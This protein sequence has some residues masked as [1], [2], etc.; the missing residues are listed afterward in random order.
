MRGGLKRIGAM[1]LMLVCGMLICFTAY[2]QKD[3]PDATSKFVNDFA[4]VISDE[5]E[6]EMSERAKALYEAY[7]EKIQVMVV[8]IESLGGESISDY[9]LR[10]YNA[11]GI[12]LKDVNQGVMILVSIND[13]KTWITTGSGTDDYYITDD[14][15]SEI[16]TIGSPYFKSGEFGTGLKMI[17]IAAIDEFNSRMN[18]EDSAFKTLSSINKPSDIG[19]SENIEEVE[20]MVDIRNTIIIILTALM[21]IS[22]S[23]HLFQLDRNS[24]DKDNIVSLTRKKE[25]YQDELESIKSKYTRL[26]NELEGTKNELSILNFDLEELHTKYMDLSERFE[27]AKRID[28]QIEAKVAKKI[29]ESWDRRANCILNS[30]TPYDDKLEQ[31]QSLIREF[32]SLAEDVKSFITLSFDLRRHI[33]NSIDNRDREAANEIEERI[34]K[35]VNR[36]YKVSSGDYSN[37]SGAKSLYE[38]LNDNARTFVD[39]ALIASVFS[40]L[41]ISERLREEEKNERER[42]RRLREEEA[43]FFSSSDSSNDTSSFDA[44]D[45]GSFDAGDGGSSDGGGGGADW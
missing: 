19:Y 25:R 4:N 41:Q 12:G 18:V 17:Q 32:D 23:L 37:L 36:I 30:S 6:L 8:T 7:P 35:K 22:I 33:K 43:S 15:A 24:K 38:S 26:K 2:A 10:M 44:V 1:V 16:A 31:S 45:G 39:R 27:M 40:R 21:I 3:I 14:R 5:V 34:R 9:A 11:Y 29:A 20:K 28:P 13:R 42:R